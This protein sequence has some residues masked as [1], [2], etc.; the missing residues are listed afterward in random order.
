M[1]RIPTGLHKDPKGWH[2][3]D[4]DQDEFSLIEQSIAGDGQALELLLSRY[5]TPIYSF[6]LS[7]TRD[8]P[9]AEDVTQETCI[10]IWKHLKRFDTAK[11]FKTWV[12]AI[13]KNTAYDALKKKKALPFSAFIDND[14]DVQESWEARIADE[15]PLADEVLSRADIREELN[16][17]LKS[18]P[19]HF[20]QILRMHYQEDFSLNEIADI[21]GEPYNTIKSRHGRAIRALKKRFSEGNM[22]LSG[23]EGM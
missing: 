14:D 18:I 23:R 7:L 12:F 6:V 5:M 4:M 9:M 8:V 15:E 17:W 20:E 22:A 3:A 10:K 2:N 21:L 13:A 16:L 19:A 11:S 1:P